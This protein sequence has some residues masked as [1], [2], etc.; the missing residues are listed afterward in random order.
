[1]HDFWTEIMKDFSHAVK[2]PV[3]VSVPKMVWDEIT[4]HFTS[5]INKIINERYIL[6]LSALI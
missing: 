2:N 1:M 5:G 3:I 4:V 6:I